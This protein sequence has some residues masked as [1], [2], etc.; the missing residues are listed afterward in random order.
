MFLRSTANVGHLNAIYYVHMITHMD[1]EIYYMIL[2]ANIHGCHSKKQSWLN[3]GRFL[4]EK[5]T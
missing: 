4:D 3:Y 5:M 2:Y 1:K